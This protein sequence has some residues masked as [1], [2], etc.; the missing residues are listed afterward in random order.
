M[1]VIHVTVVAAFSG[2]A[3][4]VTVPLM[5]LAATIIVAAGLAKKAEVQLAYAIGVAHP[6]SV[7]ITLWYKYC[8]WEQIVRQQRQIFGSS[9]CRDYPNARPR[10]QSTVKQQHMA[11]WDGQMSTSGERLDKVETLKEAV[12]WLVEMEK[13]R[14]KMILAFFVLKIPTDGKIGLIPFISVKNDS[15]RKKKKKRLERN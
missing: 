14:V 15:K 7:R 2:D 13:V 12:K 11:I 10:V 8:C 6:A 4:K 3:T 9:S 5:Q 1:V